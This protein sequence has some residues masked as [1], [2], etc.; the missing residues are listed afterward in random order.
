[1][2]AGQQCYGFLCIAEALPGAAPSSYSS[3]KPKRIEQQPE[4][5][6][7]PYALRSLRVV[8][9]KS[10]LKKQ[11]EGIGILYCRVVFRVTIQGNI[12]EIILF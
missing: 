5:L 10:K 3:W 4:T 12:G 11:I 1:M 8:G 9:E 6:Y 2:N 7:F